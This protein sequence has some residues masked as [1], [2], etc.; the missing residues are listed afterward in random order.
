LAS[1]GCCKDSS[2]AF[3]AANCIRYYPVKHSF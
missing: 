1:L 3:K 2:V